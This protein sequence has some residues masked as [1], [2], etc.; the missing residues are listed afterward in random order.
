MAEVWFGSGTVA[1]GVDQ[2]KSSVLMAGNSRQGGKK[3]I[4]GIGQRRRIGHGL[5]VDYR[6]ENPCNG[7]STFVPFCTVVPFPLVEVLQ[8]HQAS[9]LCHSCIDYLDNYELGSCHHVCEPA[10]D[11]ILINCNVVIG[12]L[13]IRTSLSVD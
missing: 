9:T 3:R 13:T 7:S 4:Q 10:I 2:S 5:R 1:N 11:G 8:G 6:S 12:V